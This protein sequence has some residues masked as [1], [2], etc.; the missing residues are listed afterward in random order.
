MTVTAAASEPG[1]TAAASAWARSGAMAL[2]GPSSGNPIGPPA[3]LVDRIGS[4]GAEIAARSAALGAPVA[5]DWLALLGER[6]ALA[7]LARRGRISCGGAT[8]LLPTAD[9]W[10]AVTLARSDDVELIPAWLSIDFEHD[11]PWPALA[12]EL[13]VRRQ[14]DVVD[15]GALLGLAVGGL[16]ERAPHDAATNQGMFAG[17]PVGANEVGTAAPPVVALDG[18]LV[19]DLTALWAGPLCTSI[20]ALAGA[21]VVKVESL[22]RPE[23][24]RRSKDG[25]F[26]LL[27][28]G[29]ASVV[30]DLDGSS[31]R[32]ILADLV[33]AADVVV[34]SSRPRAMEHFGIV[35]HDALG[36]R[37]GP[38]I[39]LAVNGHG[40]DDGA[41]RVAFGDDAAVAGGLVVDDGSGPQFCADAIA[42][43]ATGL[44]AAA[45]C[46]RALSA[47]GRWLIDVAMAGVA[48]EL[49]G[50]TLPAAPS[51]VVAAPRARRPLAAVR[52]LGA[53]TSAVLARVL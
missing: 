5:L 42:D 14:A 25:F 23:G 26:D 32:R 12:R 27:N 34:E 21:D 50:P 1:P 7:G 38:R 52:P 4:F 2:T 30:L 20:L 35:A 28:A 15:R 31:G 10:I 18:L 39:W 46:L 43:P 36:D 40:R 8:R 48:A 24:M 16:R 45:A 6:A 3:P 22:S 51:T 9:G 33:R 49:A 47:G 29:K 37:K 44:V 41:F 11:D 53:D 13:A 17:L 19:V